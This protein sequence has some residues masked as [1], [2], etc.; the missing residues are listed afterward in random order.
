M[1]DGAPNFL[2]Q[3]HHRLSWKIR[4]NFLPKNMVYFGE[5]VP[6]GVAG[7]ALLPVGP[8]GRAAKVFLFKVKRLREKLWIGVIQPVAERIPEVNGFQIFERHLLQL[9]VKKIHR[10]RDNVANVRM[11][12]H[13]IEKTRQSKQRIV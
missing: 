12:R 6:H 13:L 7:T 9:R 3:S 4:K 10:A 2:R 11:F 5:E 8:Y 1:N